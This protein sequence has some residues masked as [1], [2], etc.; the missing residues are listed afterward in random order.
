MSCRSSSEPDAQSGQERGPAGSLAAI[1]QPLVGGQEPA[2]QAGAQ[3]QQ[4]AGEQL[5]EYQEPQQAQQASSA[6]KQS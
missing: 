2:E 1:Q 3:G 6:C 5:E 4:Q